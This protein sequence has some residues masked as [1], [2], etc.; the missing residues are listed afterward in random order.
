MMQKE[1]QFLEEQNVDCHLLQKVEDFR[2]E[3]AVREEIQDRKSNG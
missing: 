3:Y 2:K 1:L